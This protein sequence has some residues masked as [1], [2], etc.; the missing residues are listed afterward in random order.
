M[1][2]GKAISA[3]QATPAMIRILTVETFDDQTVALKTRERVSGSN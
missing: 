2:A 3:A 1:G